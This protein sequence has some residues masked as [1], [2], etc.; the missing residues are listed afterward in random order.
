MFRVWGDEVKAVG[1]RAWRLFRISRPSAS[2]KEIWP[3]SSECFL[4]GV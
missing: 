3:N 1:L 2:S 4:R